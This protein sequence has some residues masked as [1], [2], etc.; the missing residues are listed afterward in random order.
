[1]RVI[2]PTRLQWTFTDLDSIETTEP[3]DQT[4]TS[5]L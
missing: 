3:I 1:M 5:K 4:V 2:L